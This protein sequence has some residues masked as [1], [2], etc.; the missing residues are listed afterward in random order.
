MQPMLLDSSLY[1][2]QSLADT[3]ELGAIRQQFKPLIWIYLL[4]F[5]ILPIFMMVT[6]CSMFAGSSP[7]AMVGWLPFAIIFILV[8]GTILALVYRARKR[9]IYVCE[10]G[11]LAI[12]SKGVEAIRWDEI[13]VVWHKVARNKNSVTHSYSIQRKDGSSFKLGMFLSS[14]SQLGEIIQEEVARLLF[15]GVQAAFEQ[16][17]P[18]IFGPLILDR[19]GL[20]CREKF[21]P[22]N[23][24]ERIKF[25]TDHVSIKARDKFFAWANVRYG[26]VPNLRLFEKLTNRFVI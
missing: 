17:R 21:L 8:S 11:L 5:S 2:P 15:P 26:D 6:T 22:W 7:S 19:S 1:D 23:E 14:N 25:T 18:L 12:R 20:T 10:R 24:I 3:Y 13:A 16:G 9:Y 4:I